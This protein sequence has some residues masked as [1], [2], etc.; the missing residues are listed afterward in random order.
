MYVCALFLNV[1]LKI[2]NLF[3]VLFTSFFFNV[4][5]APYFIETFDSDFSETHTVPIK[6]TEIDQNF[7]YLSND[8]NGF[9]E[10]LAFKE[11][12]GSFKAINKFGYMGKYQFNLNTLKIYK[13]KNS[14]NFINNPEL[15]ERVFLINCQRNKWVLRKDIVW[16]VGTEINGIEI[17]ESG[18]LAA[19]HLSGPGNV[20]KYLR[21]SG[22]EDLKDAFG[23]SIS[24]YL[25][26]FKNYDLSTIN[27][28]K[29]PKI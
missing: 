6:N 12:S 4:S 10:L 21:S 17:T 19:A 25:F 15:Q 1:M 18:I 29:R 5:Y 11:S 9:K 20:K 23:T 28:V 22:N 2:I 27:A 26:N 24:N 14:K 7:V 3:R 16:F 8:F 13:L